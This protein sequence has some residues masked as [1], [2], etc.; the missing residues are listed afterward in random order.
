[1][2][3]QVVHETPNCN[4]STCPTIYQDDE[5]NYIIQGFVLNQLE[6]SN[7]AIPDGEDAIR[8]PAAFLSSF[9]SKR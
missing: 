5:G 9:V 4:Q 8:V 7:L 2:K 3:Y 6:K 1:M